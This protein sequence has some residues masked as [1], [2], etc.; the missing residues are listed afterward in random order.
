M[1]RGPSWTLADLV[2]ITTDPDRLQQT[3]LSTPD[4]AAIASRHMGHPKTFS[5][6]FHTLA[7]AMEILEGIAAAT[8]AMPPHRRVGIGEW[9]RSKG[10]ILLL[11]MDF[12]FPEELGQ[13]Y[14][15]IFDTIARHA[16]DG[17]PSPARWKNWFFLEDVDTF[18]S[19]AALPRLLTSG[20]AFGARVA[21]SCMDI[22][23][24]QFLYG[25][26]SGLE[27]LS[28]C[29]NHSIL[30]QISIDTADWAAQLAS[31]QNT[32]ECRS[33]Q[34]S[35]ELIEVDL[36][37]GFRDPKLFRPRP[38]CKPDDF[39]TFPIPSNGHVTGCH[40]SRSLGGAVVRETVYDISDGRPA[41]T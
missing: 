33:A 35:Q 19:F 18:P 21:F 27:L 1:Q 41:A 11:E 23:S 4:S 13:L 30:R 34:A 6:T 38:G 10:S 37:K 16:V 3:L 20:R 12:R 24:M 14:R 5:N 26:K 31:D 25:E 8:A 17:L 7:G 32:Y 9:S 15:L 29:A 39:Y 2:E 36:N 22:E 28:A 40:I